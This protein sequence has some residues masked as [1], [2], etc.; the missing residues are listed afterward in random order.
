M[1]IRNLEADGASVEEPVNL[2]PEGSEGSLISKDSTEGKL[3]SMYVS[4]SF[5]LDISPLASLVC[6]DRL[7]CLGYKYI[8]SLIVRVF[9]TRSTNKLYFLHT[10][11]FSAT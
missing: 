7:G 5:Y 3:E 4:I 9:I 1:A 10:I 8:P 6:R 2:F 11:S